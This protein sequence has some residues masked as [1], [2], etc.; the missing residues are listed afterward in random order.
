MKKRRTMIISLLLVAAL[1]LGVGYATI[2]SRLNVN[3]TANIDINTDNFL[4]EFTGVTYD[5][6]DFPTEGLSATA[7]GLTATFNVSALNKKDDQMVFTYT[8]KNN[9]PGQYNAYLSNIVVDADS[10]VLDD[11]NSPLTRSEYYT[12]DAELEDN[13]LAYGDS[14]TLTVT[15]TCVKSLTDN[16]TLTHR[17]HVLTS[18]DEFT[19]GSVT[20]QPIGE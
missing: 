13:E 16:A 11:D 5:A 3:G 15:V 12:I 18:T 19:T 14:T 2:S 1:A 17:F 6:G 4:V 10:L 8:I 9:S 7:E 20:E